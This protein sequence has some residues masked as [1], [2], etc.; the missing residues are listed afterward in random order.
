MAYKSRVVLF[1]RRSLFM[2]I[3][4]RPLRSSL[5]TSPSKHKQALAHAFY[6][7]S[8]TVEQVLMSVC[9]SKLLAFDVYCDYTYDLQLLLGKHSLIHSLSR[10]V[11]RL[12]GNGGCG[13]YPQNEVRKIQDILVPVGYLGEHPC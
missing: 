4:D 13:A 7:H 10:R 6:F 3:D 2:M 11:N 9:L 5:T 8:I 12:I 1:F